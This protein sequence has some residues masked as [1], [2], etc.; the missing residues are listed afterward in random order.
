M[1]QAEFSRL[2]GISATMVSKY[3]AKG[4]L[5]ISYSGMV[6]ARASLALLKGHMNDVTYQAALVRLEDYNP[7]TH[8]KPKFQEFEAPKTWRAKRDQ[9]DA[10]S[11]ELEYRVR[12]GE[13]VDASTVALIVET[14]FSDLMTETERLIQIDSAEFGA[15]LNLSVDQ[16]RALKNLRIHQFRQ[17]RIEIVRRCREVLHVTS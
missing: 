7:P 5:S 6:R 13:L 11:R 2:C 16:S 4:R 3:R 10:L 1:T 15:K 12:T 8:E 17:Y 9:I 14:T